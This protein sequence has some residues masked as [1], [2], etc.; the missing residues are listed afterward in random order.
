ML[1]AAG[2]FATPFELAD[3]L[4][5]EPVDLVRPDGVFR[6]EMRK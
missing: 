2:D 4:G 6:S 5:A 3:A 1:S